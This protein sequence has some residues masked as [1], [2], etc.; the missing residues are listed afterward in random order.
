MSSLF[1]TA[2]RDLL[3]AQGVSRTRY[4]R[5]RKTARAVGWAHFREDA[6]TVLFKVGEG[7]EEYRKTLRRTERHADADT[8]PRSRIL[9]PIFSRR[10]VRTE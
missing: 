3:G 7:V 6:D 2:A 4:V 1:D 9:L 5:R 10:Q 8:V